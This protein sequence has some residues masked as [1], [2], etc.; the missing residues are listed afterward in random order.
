MF[1][2]L[3]AQVFPELAMLAGAVSFAMVLIRLPR[4]AG[5]G[6]ARPFRGRVLLWFVGFEAYLVALV[7]VGAPWSVATWWL[8]G[9][10]TALGFMSLKGIDFLV[11]KKWLF[12]GVS[13]SVLGVLLLPILILAH[14]FPV[15]ALEEASHIASFI[16][17][18]LLELAFALALLRRDSRGHFTWAKKNH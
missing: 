4:L 3:W 12:V 11:R 8:V 18:V 17:F 7:Y 15:A 1:I 16:G 5:H 14:L 13:Y 2:S 9:H 10:L 6:E